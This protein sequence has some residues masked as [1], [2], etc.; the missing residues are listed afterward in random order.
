MEEPTWGAEG[1]GILQRRVIGVPVKARG[2]CILGRSSAQY[3]IEAV[4]LLL[5]GCWCGRPL[6]LVLELVATHRCSAFIPSV[7]CLQGFVAQPA[8]DAAGDLGLWQH[9]RPLAG[10]AA[11][12]GMTVCRMIQVFGSLI[13][14]TVSH[15]LTSLLIR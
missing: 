14:Q 10:T 7:I 8:A 13:S 3:A 15:L 5:W 4:S 11:S 2:S 1:G 12:V 6:P 9:Q